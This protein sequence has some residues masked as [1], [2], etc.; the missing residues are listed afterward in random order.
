MSVK[1]SFLALTPHICREMRVYTIRT[2]YSTNLYQS[3]NRVRRLSFT[4][5][6][7]VLSFAGW[8]QQSTNPNANVFFVKIDNLN[9]D[10]YALL[11]HAVKADGRFNIDLACVPGKMLT[12]R[13]VGTPDVDM[14]KNVQNFQQVANQAQ[15]SQAL[16]LT[17]FNAMKFYEACET[18]RN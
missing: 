1:V 15:L 16:L 12:I 4:L 6:L 9:V 2:T 8:S 10:N 7:A 3:M 17:E 5:L 18:F 14:A 13:I 11:H